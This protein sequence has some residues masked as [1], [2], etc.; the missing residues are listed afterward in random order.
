MT[1]GPKSRR[2]L[3]AEYHRYALAANALDVNFRI[4]S[5]GEHLGESRRRCNRR[6]E[7]HTALVFASIDALVALSIV[8]NQWAI[9]TFQGIACSGTALSLRAVLAS[10]SRSQGRWQQLSCYARRSK[11][12]SRARQV[13]NEIKSYG[14]P[15]T[16]VADG[17]IKLPHV[18]LFQG[19]RTRISASHRSKSR[20]TS[21]A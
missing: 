7:L 6:I 19:C 5:A 10:A 13:P 16:R 8:N 14:D 4:P 21:G 17:H 18:I 2:I 9:S 11:M 3:Y 15:K 12:G 1:T 20:L